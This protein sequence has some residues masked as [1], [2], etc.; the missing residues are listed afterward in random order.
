MFN[1]DDPQSAKHLYSGSEVSCVQRSAVPCLQL[2]E[3]LSLLS[4]VLGLMLLLLFFLFSFYLFLIL[5]S[6]FPVQNSAI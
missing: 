2:G 1:E 6:F 4:N 5:G 3:H